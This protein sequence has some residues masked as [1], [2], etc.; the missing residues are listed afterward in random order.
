MDK[1]PMGSLWDRPKEWHSRLLSTEHSLCQLS[2]FVTEYL[3][4]IK[5]RRDLFW[6]MDVEVSA[7]HRSPHLEAETEREG[8][9]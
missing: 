8:A 1:L 9:G 6:F 3:R 4:K 5:W 2:I 7:I